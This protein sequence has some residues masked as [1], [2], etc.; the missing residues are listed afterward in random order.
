MATSDSGKKSVR[1]AEARRV[2]NVR[3]LRAMKDAIKR[4]AGFVH[5]ED[6]KG[7]EE[8]LPKAYKAIDKATK[9]GILKKNT[10]DRRK[11]KLTRDIVGMK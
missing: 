6:K 7:A 2:F 9:S 1:Q 5:N 10:A 8:I 11:A 4:I 3:R